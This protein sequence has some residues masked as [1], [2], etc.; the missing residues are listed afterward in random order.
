MR[1]VI[2]VVVIDQGR[3]LL[4]RKGEFWILPGGKPEDGEADL[5]CL[6]RELGEELSGLEMEPPVFLGEFIGT[7]PYKGYTFAAQV[8]MAD[9][10]GKVFPKAEIN[11]AEWTDQ[12]ETYNLSDALI[13]IV[14]HLR[15]QGYL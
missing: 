4:V 14:A 2:C 9:G 12:P 3:I 15:Q 10:S 5:D 7:A 11:A 1:R 8:Y 6:M 13:K